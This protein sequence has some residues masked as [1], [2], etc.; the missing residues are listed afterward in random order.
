MSNPK[1]NRS[2]RYVGMLALSNSDSE[3]S[4]TNSSSTYIKIP[5]KLKPKNTTRR[6]YTQFR[7]TTKQ[8]RTMLQKALE[9]LNQKHV[10]D[11]HRK[12]F[13]SN[14]RRHNIKHIMKRTRMITYNFIR[15]KNLLIRVWKGLKTIVKL[16]NP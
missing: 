14:P 7:G 2:A 5:T 9:I 1:T 3:D 6:G 13:P 11:N 16:N 15:L 4:N 10:S 8:E 12:F